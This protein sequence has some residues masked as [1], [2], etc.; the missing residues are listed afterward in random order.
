VPER[1]RLTSSQAEFFDR[2]PTHRLVAGPAQAAAAIKAYAG[3]V[4][5]DRRELIISH[6]NLIN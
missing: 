2:L 5:E 3:P 1:H 4:T 6:G